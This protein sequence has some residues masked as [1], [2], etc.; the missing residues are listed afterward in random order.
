MFLTNNSSKSVDKYIEKLKSLGL[1][2]EEREFVPH[3]TLARKFKPGENF[4]FNV[5]AKGA[6]IAKIS[7]STPIA[8]NRRK[9]RIRAELSILRSASGN[10]GW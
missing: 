7:D 10:L 1:E 3:I 8:F 4:P 2:L 6:E 5:Y 9:I